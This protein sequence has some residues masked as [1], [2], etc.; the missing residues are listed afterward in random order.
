MRGIAIAIVLGL[1]STQC[2]AQSAPSSGQCEQVRAAIA[3]HG[4]QAARQH[5]VANHGLSR[6]DLR[7]IEQSCGIGQRAG[8]AKRSK[9]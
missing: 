1:L 9:R 5:A 4:L 6:A 3:Q 2:Y 7:T 8:R